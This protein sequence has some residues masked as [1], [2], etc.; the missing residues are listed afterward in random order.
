[1]VSLAGVK[2]F[3]HSWLSAFKTD[4]RKKDDSVS[5]ASVGGD[6]DCDP[7]D[8]EGGDE[9]AAVVSGDS[10]ESAAVVSDSDDEDTDAGG[11]GGRDETA[12]A[13]PDA[14]D[15]VCDAGGDEAAA[16]VSGDL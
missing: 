10:D 4:G 16:V 2:P 9:A 7:K 14:D 3:L 8:G 1:M 5:T 11:D 13:V 12:A 15:G 6:G